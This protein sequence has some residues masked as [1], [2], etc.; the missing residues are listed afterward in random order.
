MGSLGADRVATGVSG[1]SGPSGASPPTGV[2]GPSGPS[3]ATPPA[4]APEPPQGDGIGLPA[5]DLAV[6]DPPQVSA[7]G[8]VLYEP[9]EDVVLG[10]DAE[11]VGR[12]MASTTKIMTVLLALEALH[13]GRVGPEVLVSAHAVE[14]G[15]S[16]GA[17]TLDLVEGETYTLTDILA[18]LILRSGNDGAVA[19][20]EHV[21]GSEEAFTAQM[22]ARAREL[23]LGET[24]FLNATGL[25]DDEGHHASPLDLALL[26]ALAMQNPDF[27]SWAGSA[28]LELEDFGVL[29]SRNLLLGAFAGAT[30]VKTGFTALA[31]N[32]LVAS[33][34]RDGRVLFAVVLGSEDSFA[35]A[36]AL[37]EYG[38]ATWARPVALAA[39][40]AAGTYRWS[41]AET[42]LV[43]GGDLTRT[44]PAAAEVT[45]RR[46][47]EPAIPRPVTAGTVM[48]HV[49][50][51]VAGQLANRVDLVAASGVPAA[52]PPTGIRATA[53]TVGGLVAD[54]LR[55]YARLTP[56]DQAS[57]TS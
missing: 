38:F 24:S 28:S 31:G 45:T 49:D 19:V 39:A 57:T 6:P 9:A 18:A 26:G 27:A 37:L 22:N 46:W 44:V 55:V 48:G 3:G 14:V 11:G 29:D 15:A 17:A 40:A 23:G 33:A 30:G 12:P 41:G 47:L 10:G 32:C 53:A 25:T 42:S 35:D 13:D 50:L 2:S 56:V 34:R 51:L 7:T 21:A 54:A 43:A 4:G 36:S 16:P 8:W 52:E 1:P 20:A 5:L